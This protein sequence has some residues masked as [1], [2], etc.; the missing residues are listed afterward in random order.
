MTQIL[1]GDYYF[2]GGNVPPGSPSYVARDADDQLFQHLLEG[3]FC[4]V[5]TSRQMGKSS[6]MTRMLARLRQ[7]S[8]LPAV[9]DLSG[10]GYQLTP[11]HWYRGLLDQLGKRLN[12]EDEMD[13]FCAANSGLSPLQLW[14]SGLR[15]VALKCTDRDLVIFVDEID[16]VR[17]LSFSV[18][19]FFASIRYCY[20]ARSEDPIYNRVRF[21]LLGVAT[22]AQLVREPTMTPFNI[23]VPILLKDFSRSEAGSLEAGL[24]GTVDQRASTMD[25]VI[26]WTN[27]QPYPT[28]L[29]GNRRN[30]HSVSLQRCGCDR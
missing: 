1:P 19:E 7:H 11:E 6:L 22:P 27:G 8:I 13:D 9:L 23:G 3:K 24:P 18:D 4:Y 16:M 21:C 15:D 20:N 30:R 10:Q 2:A 17:R 25:R 14:Q 5:L 12:I 29:P 28:H 26:Y